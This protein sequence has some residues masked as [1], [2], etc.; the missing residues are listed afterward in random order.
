M[1]EQLL[2]KLGIHDYSAL[3]AEEKKTYE[4]WAKVLVTGDPTIEGVKKFVASEYER[5]IEECQKFENSKDRQL[6]FQALARLTG[7]LK[8]FLETPANQREALKSHLKQV[9]HID[10]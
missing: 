5:A 3:T 9:F 1:L 7:T 10:V 8:T 2:E 6:F 4:T